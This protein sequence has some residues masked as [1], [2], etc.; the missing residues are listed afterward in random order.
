MEK[1]SLI[2]PILNEEENITPLYE[3]TCRMMENLGGNFEI[4]FVIELVEFVR[5]LPERMRI[6]GGQTNWVPQSGCF[7]Q[8]YEPGDTAAE[9]NP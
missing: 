1:V 7:L 9:V 2:I 5:H 6:N 3:N 8:G 4:M